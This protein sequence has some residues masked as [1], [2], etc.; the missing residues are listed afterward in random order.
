MATILLTGAN[1]TVTAPTIAALK[2]SGHRLIG[3]V[4][5][6]AKGKALDI[7]LRKG[8][9]DQPRSIEGAFDGVDTAWLL[10]APGPLQP[11]Q[12]SNAIWAARQAG[13]RHIVR[14]SA[15]GAAHDAPTVNSRLH[16]I[17]DEELKASGIAYTIFKPHM[18]MQT[19]LW[20]AE[21]IAKEGVF[22]FAFGDAA[23]P[24]IDVADIAAAA[25]SV[26]DNPRPHV[27]KTYTLTG[28]AAVTGQQMGAAIGEAIGKPVKY[29]PIPVPTMVDG[30]AK[31][32]LGDYVE[33]AVRDYLNAYSRGW[34]SQVTDAVRKL[35]GKTPRTVA[36][37][38]REN[39]A[40]FGKR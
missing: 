34:S 14:M 24:V 19:F 7:E 17:S 9:L 3:L 40:A 28:P 31:M 1:G 12:M 25:A 32:G 10:S 30:I 15:V 26:L 33:V 18:F 38:A 16:A 11:Y 13:V 23:V 20:T 35:T 29:L 2:S 6:E 4:R 37:F 21:G 22:A 8:D 27:G 5:D 36:E 39:A